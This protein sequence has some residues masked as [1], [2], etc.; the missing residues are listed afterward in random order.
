MIRPLLMLLMMTACNPP[1]HEQEARPQATEGKWLILEFPDGVRGRGGS[2]QGRGRSGS[3]WDE[4]VDRIKACGA[5]DARRVDVMSHYG[6]VISRST[7]RDR[8][9]VG[10]VMLAVPRRFSAGIGS[11]DP[12]E[13]SGMDRSPFR[14]FETLPHRGD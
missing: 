2:I 5:E 12:L 3:T 6:H 14:E 4:L 1:Q 11:A 9:V 7:S 8:Q 13:L 10:C